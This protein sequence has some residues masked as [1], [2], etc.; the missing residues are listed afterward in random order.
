[1]KL[2]NRKQL[3]SWDKATMEAFNNSSA[4]LMERAARACAEMLVDKAPGG[5]YVFFCGT[6]N[7]GGDGLVMARLLHEQQMKVDVIVVGDPKKG[8][9]DFRL[10]LQRALDGDIP[11]DF[12]NEMPDVL[13]VEW[14][15]VVVDAIIGSGLNRP[16]EGWLADLIDEINVLT[17]PIVSIDIPTGLDADKMEEQDGAIVNADITLTIEVPKRSMLFPENDCYVGKMVVVPLGLD[18]EFAEDEPCNWHYIDDVE[19]AHVLRP[20]YKYRHKGTRGHVQLIAGSRGMMGAAML[21][22]YAALRA[23]AG[24]VTACLSECGLSLLQTTLPEVICKIGS[25]KDTCDRFEAVEGATALVIGPGIGTGAE[26]T[27]LVDG[28]LG[29]GKLPVIA[30]ADALNIV[31]REGWLKRVPAGSVITPHVG[32]FDRLFGPHHSSFDR[33]ETQLKMSSELR[34]FIVLKGAHTRITAPNGSIYINATGNPGM[35]TAGSG[36]V[37]SGM[38]GSLLAQGYEPIDASLMGVF[39]HG[40]AGDVAADVR[41][42]DSMIARDIIECIGDAFAHL[43]SYGKREG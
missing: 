19:T 42:A 4:E 6:G 27:K 20:I 16:I 38:I 33:L 2:F 28:W 1:M 31:A 22:S 7:N 29:N 36:D 15:D 18:P 17:N 34:I 11:L 39:L 10:N 30:D 14:D 40:L 3:Q 5:R 9:N 35:A 23:G 12:I 26:A 25:G 43:R 8:S 41:G 13:D 21:S 24:K 32:E 37:L